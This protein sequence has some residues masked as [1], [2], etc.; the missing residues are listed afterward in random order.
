M[1]KKNLIVAGLAA[2]AI[3]AH[4]A[5]P[6]KTDTVT[7]NITNSTA[8][9]IASQNGVTIPLSPDAA[10]GVKYS[11]VFG[12]SLDGRF[13]AGDMDAAIG[14]QGDVGS[15][16]NHISLGVAKKAGPAVLS[17]TAS[18]AREDATKALGNVSYDGARLRGE[19]IGL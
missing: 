2:A 18:G 6:P 3:G 8:S 15:S 7:G 5:E 13:V 4:A 1:S 14:I 11:S 17:L 9:I 19:Q 16:A 12:S 10:I